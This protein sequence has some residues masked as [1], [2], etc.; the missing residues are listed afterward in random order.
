MERS[1]YFPR[2]RLSKAGA[3]AEF[4]TPHTRYGDLLDTYFDRV[5]IHF[6]GDVIPAI[7]HPELTYPG[8]RPATLDEIE[9]YRSR[10]D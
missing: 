7:Y 10:F 1:K 2:T 9:I 5:W 6:N 3:A 4:K 8:H